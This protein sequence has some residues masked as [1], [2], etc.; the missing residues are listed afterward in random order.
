MKKIAR[1]ILILAAAGA[2]AWAQQWE[3]GGIG[4]ASFLNRV[5]VSSSLGAATAGFAP[6]VAGGAFFGQALYPRLAGEIHYEF[7]QS[8]Q[9]LSAGGSS[10]EFSGMAHAVHYDLVFHTNRK[11]SPVQF[12]AVVGGGMK[13]FQGTGTPGACLG[14]CQ[15]GAFTQ[16]HVVKPVGVVGGGVSFRLAPHLYLRTEVMDFVGPFPKDLIAPVAGAK[17]GSILQDIVPMVGLTYLF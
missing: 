9:K 6:G 7:F 10:A 4:G 13:I 2:A 11:N 16:T 15:F 14:L 5:N 3:V 17:F 8:S 12:F 1:T